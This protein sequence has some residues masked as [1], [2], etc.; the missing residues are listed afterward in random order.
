M[1]LLNT[2]HTTFGNANILNQKINLETLQPLFDTYLLR[3]TDLE[4]NSY[5]L[6]L[7]GC[8]LKALGGVFGGLILYFNF[9]QHI[10]FRSALLRSLPHIQ[11]VQTLTAA[12]IKHK[13]INRA[14]IKTSSSV[15]VSGVMTMTPV[16]LMACDGVV[17]CVLFVLTGGKVDCLLTVGGVGVLLMNVLLVRESLVCLNNP[18]GVGFLGATGGTGHVPLSLVV[19]LCDCSVVS[20]SVVLGGSEEVGFTV[21]AG[22]FGLV[23]LEV[24]GLVVVL[25]VVGLSVVVP[26]DVRLAL[27]VV[28]YA[29]FEVF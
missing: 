15:K 28:T 11:L 4:Y 26:G 23:G 21:P 2:A 17:I 13:T 12:M 9:L 7:E 8:L 5:S 24:V 10:F 22:S 6:P 19:H 29:G 25:A 27:V 18:S 3:L 20:E 1:K 14:S 16:T